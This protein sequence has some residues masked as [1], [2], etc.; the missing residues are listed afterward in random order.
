MTEI[1]RYKPMAAAIGRRLAARN[2]INV[3][4]M[5]D[6]ALSV[7]GD[8]VARRPDEAAVC[9][10]VSES[11]WVYRNLVWR[12]T[13][14]VRNHHRHRQRVRNVKADE[15]LPL[16]DRTTWIDRLMHQVGDD[17]WTIIDIV[18]R[19]PGELGT[20]SAFQCAR[21]RRW[22]RRYLRQEL[23]WGYHRTSAAWEEVRACIS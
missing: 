9:C 5:L 13:D 8:L 19:S 21:A 22:L 18:A 23:G 12:L 14:Y 16:P 15:E 2:G 4:E 17:A 11:T 10:R 20:M 3:R 1:D 6:E 7:L